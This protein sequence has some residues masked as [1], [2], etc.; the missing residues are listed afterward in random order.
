MEDIPVPKVE[1][2][3]QVAEF[4][5][6]D[7]EPVAAPAEGLEDEPTSVAAS[8]EDEYVDEPM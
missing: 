5:S 2:P 1:A 6:D 8:V 3:E 4:L 7:P